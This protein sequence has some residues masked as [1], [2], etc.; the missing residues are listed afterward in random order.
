MK[1]LLVPEFGEIVIS[2]REKINRTRSQKIVL[3]IVFAIFVGYSLSLLVP[4]LWML[5]NSFKTRS[6]FMG[7]S[8][9]NG[10]LSFP[11]V[12]D[13]SNYYEALVGFTV[14]VGSGESMRQLN[15]LGMFFNSI[16]VTLTSTFLE[17]F[18]SVCTAYVVTKYKFPGRWLIT[19]MVL[20][21]M[22]I[23]VVGSLPV[24]Y[25]FMNNIGL[26]DTLPGIW[27]VYVGG[28]GF[29]YLLLSGHFRSVSW[30]YAEA[31]Q[32]DGASHF[33]IFFKIMIPLSIPAIVSLAII[34]GIGYWND[35]S[36]VKIY[37]PSMPT[38]GV[39]LDTMLKE[40]KFTSDYPLMFTSI[41][42]AVA[43]IIILFCSF[44]KT[45]LSNLV[46]GGIKG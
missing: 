28:F 44:Q 37:L 24:M 12:W 40:I 10:G 35:F 4:F 16:V 31:A 26:Q 36:T 46:A 38:I 13:F 42:V 25:Q 9:N 30:T 3:G 15:L 27:F 19:G 2:R 11:N 17:V 43:P 29:G 21:S 7:E 34:T 6:Q 32:I 8:L 45:I 39:G 22:M 5:I 14:T 20:A 1:K 33:G 23:P 18:F 41:L